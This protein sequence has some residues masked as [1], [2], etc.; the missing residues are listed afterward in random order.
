MI[1]WIGVL[2]LASWLSSIGPRK[3]HLDVSGQL[4]LGLLWVAVWTVCFLGG[5]IL[6]WILL[7]LFHFSLEGGIKTIFDVVV[8]SAWQVF[9]DL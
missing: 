2:H 1:R 7:V 3:V 9:C 8:S 6:Q 5:P 4:P